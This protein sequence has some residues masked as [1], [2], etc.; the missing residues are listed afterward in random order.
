MPSYDFML[1]LPTLVELYD[2]CYSMLM[3]DGILNQRVR[4]YTV[5]TRLSIATTTASRPSQAGRNILDFALLL[6]CF[7][8]AHV[9]YILTTN[10][11]LILKVRDIFFSRAKHITRHFAGFVLPQTKK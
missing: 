1:A 2:Q 4:T 5:C 6:P 10:I 8:D 3:K 11:L 9:K 7:A